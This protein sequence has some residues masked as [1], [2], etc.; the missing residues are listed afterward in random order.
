MFSK[1]LLSVDGTSVKL[2]GVVSLIRDFRNIV[3]KLI[4]KVAEH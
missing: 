4:S 3:H 2:V 1:V